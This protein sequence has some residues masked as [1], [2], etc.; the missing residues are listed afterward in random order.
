MIL[1]TSQEQ[2]ILL[3]KNLQTFAILFNYEGCVAI[4]IT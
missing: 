2:I 1:K 4:K 3:Y